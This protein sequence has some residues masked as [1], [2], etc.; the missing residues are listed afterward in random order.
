MKLDHLLIYHTKKMNSKCIKDLNV[1]PETIKI[2]EEN[3][4]RKTSEQFPLFI[5]IFYLIYSPQARKQ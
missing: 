2:V 3:I 4:G 5:E 1:K